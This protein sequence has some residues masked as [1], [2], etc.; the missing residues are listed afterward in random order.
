MPFNVSEDH[1]SE[2]FLGMRAAVLLRQYGQLRGQ[3]P[4]G[5]DF[6]DWTLADMA[7][8]CLKQNARGD[9]RL[10]VGDLSDDQVIDEA[11][12]DGGLRWQGT[13]NFASLLA[14]VAEQAALR[15]WRNASTTFQR[16]CRL[17]ETKTFREAER[18]TADG[19]DELPE[20]G[21][22]SE[23]REI[24]LATRREPV[25]TRTFGAKVSISRQALVNDDISVLTV[26]PEAAG[27]AAARTVNGLVYA[28]LTANSGTGPLLSDGTALFASDHNNYVSSG[29]AP[30]VATLSALRQKLRRQADPVSGKALNIPGKYLLVPPSLES[31]ARVLAAADA[32]EG[33]EENLQVIVEPLLEDGTDGTTAWYLLADGDAFDTVEVH[34][35][36]G[37][38]HPMLEQ[39]PQP[40]ERDGRMFAV[41]VT[42]G[43]AALDFRAM[44]RNKGA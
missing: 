4:A 23:R 7:R 13:D 44:T 12:K 25:Q 5:R 33:D 37:P 30:T 21:E 14:G 36:G 35:V 8:Q 38:P 39:A 11:L 40:L 18:A 6:A 2:A 29:G 15:G 26:T 9:A 28:A 1:R 43:V 22:H 20:L 41:T 3:H 31:A 32:L 42:A 17:G 34:G 19:I 10:R 16:W 24:I 27:R